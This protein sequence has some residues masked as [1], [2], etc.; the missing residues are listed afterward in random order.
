MTRSQ[1]SPREIFST[2]VVADTVLKNKPDERITQSVLHYLEQQ[3]RKGL[4]TFFEDG[5]IY[6]PDTDT[7]ALGYS[8]LL[9][10]GRATKQETYRVF[11]SILRYQDENGLIQ[12]WL[13]Q[14]RSNRTDPVVSANALYLAYLLGR[15][16][17]VTKTES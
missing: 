13:S 14:D 7:N 16:N 8:L 9:E 11:D 15:N 5:S 10:T 1:I 4:F 3:K 17:E 6:P 12:V 2:L